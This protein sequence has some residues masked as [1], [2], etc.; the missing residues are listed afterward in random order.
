MYVTWLRSQVVTYRLVGCQPLQL[1]HGALS[2]VV[3]IA[4]EMALS[5][6]PKEKARR[7]GAP[8]LVYVAHAPVWVVR[9]RYI[10]L[11]LE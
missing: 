3:A 7:A 5:G 4:P 6:T 8:R 10:G 11:K 2:H 9:I 1:S